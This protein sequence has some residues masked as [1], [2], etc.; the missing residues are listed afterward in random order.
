MHYICWYWS[1]STISL[2]L[3]I[4]V[5]VHFIY[6][7]WAIRFS[8][9]KNG[10][11]VKLKPIGYQW[12][13]F[14][15]K[16]FSGFCEE[17]ERFIFDGQFELFDSKSMRN[18]I[19]SLQLFFDLIFGKYIIKSYKLCEEILLFVSI[20]TWYKQLISFSSYWTK[21]ICQLY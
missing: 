2:Q 14:N 3:L 13:I 20:S 6:L 8:G 17:D 12:A 9:E 19:L 7:Y 21:I 10:I 5:I 15:V 4:V 18:E 1:Q 16:W 11:V